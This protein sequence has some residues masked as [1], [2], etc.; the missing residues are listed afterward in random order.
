MALTDAV[1]RLHNGLAE[2]AVVLCKAGSA[3]ESIVGLF[4]AFEALGRAPGGVQVLGVFSPGRNVVFAI[5]PERRSA[6]ES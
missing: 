1:G 2:K 4:D 3:D 6:N 5:N